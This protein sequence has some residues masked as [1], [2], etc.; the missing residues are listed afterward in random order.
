VLVG[1]YVGGQIS[2]NV[3]KDWSIFAGAQFQDVG[4]YTH[5]SHSSAETAVLDL[6][7]SIFVNFGISHSF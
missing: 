5:H 2:V 1:G 3:A 4:T 6:R 7:K